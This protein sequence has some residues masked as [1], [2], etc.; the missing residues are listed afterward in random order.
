MGNMVWPG[1]S[2]S[3]QPRPGAFASTATARSRRPGVDARARFGAL[4]SWDNEPALSWSSFGWAAARDRQQLAS[5]QQASQ[6]GSSVPRGV[7]ALG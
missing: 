5:A 2:G 3:D 6:R 4:P 7:Q 1:W